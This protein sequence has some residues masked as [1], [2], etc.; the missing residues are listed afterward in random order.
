MKM[1]NDIIAC[2]LNSNLI[3]WVANGCKKYWKFACNYDVAK[4]IL[5][6]HFFIAF[7]LT[8]I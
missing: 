8:M 3:K 4:I 6:R 5:K 7:Y 2:N 1:F